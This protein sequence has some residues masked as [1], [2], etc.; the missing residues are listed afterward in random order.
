MKKAYLIIFVVYILVVLKLTI[1]RETTFSGY[2]LN[3]KLFTELIKVYNNS[4]IW[5]FLRLFLG[6]IGWFMPFGFLLPLIKRNKFL[7]VLLSGFGF[8]FA[9]ELLQLVFKKGFCEIDDLI[10]N[11]IGTA[12]GYAVYRVWIVVYE[13]LKH[14]HS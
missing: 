6:N 11:T 1:F 7:T 9:I 4:S 2:R 3:L 13:R 10:L 5:V 8:S 12:V 14:K